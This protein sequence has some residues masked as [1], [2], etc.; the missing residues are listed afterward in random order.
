M[1]RIRPSWT[2]RG[3]KVPFLLESPTS[4]VGTYNHGIL[5]KSRKKGKR[6]FAVF[7][8][9]RLV[10]AKI[11]KIADFL[12]RVRH[13]AARSRGICIMASVLGL[14]RGKHGDCEKSLVYIRP[15]L[16][17]PRAKMAR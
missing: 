15:P 10:R 7:R 13:R 12:D 5:V 2:V 14:E 17:V 16:P 11:G 4:L 3:R 9:F 8:E 6:N 1:S